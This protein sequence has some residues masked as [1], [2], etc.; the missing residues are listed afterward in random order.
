MSVITAAA[1]AVA[2]A[3]LGCTFGHCRH[4]MKLTGG[5][6]TYTFVYSGGGGDARVAET[7]HKKTANAVRFTIAHAEAVARCEIIVTVDSLL[8][9]ET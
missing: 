4:N 8:I 3:S 6:R 9:G 5:G 1:A 7:P 2:V